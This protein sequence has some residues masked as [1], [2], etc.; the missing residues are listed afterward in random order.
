MRRI[1]KTAVEKKREPE[2]Q[3]APVRDIAAA[4]AQSVAEVMTPAKLTPNVAVDV[5]LSPVI[6]MLQKL[7]LYLA[8]QDEVE[9]VVKRDPD[10]Q[11]ISSLVVKRNG[12]VN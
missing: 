7:E 12:T 10:T 8:G 1:P 6:D 2:A 9:L 5:D 4:V 3:Q 11:L